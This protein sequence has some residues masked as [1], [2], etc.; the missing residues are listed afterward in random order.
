MSAFLQRARQSDP[1]ARGEIEDLLARTPEGPDRAGLEIALVFLGDGSRIRIEPFRYR[2]YTLGYMGIEA[3]E[4]F[5]G[6]E[7]LDI[8][9]RAVAVHPFGAVNVEAAEAFLRV[10]GFHPDCRGECRATR[11]S[12]DLEKWWKENGADFVKRKRAESGR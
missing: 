6:A 1:D 12:D 3:I 9:L 4:R 2:S 11:H 10:T 8:L 5:G 7:G